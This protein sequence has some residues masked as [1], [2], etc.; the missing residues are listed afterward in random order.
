[1]TN[2]AAAGERADYANRQAVRENGQ[3]SK[4]VLLPS[5]NTAASFWITNPDNAHRDNVA[6]G[7]DSNGFWMSLPGHP[8]DKLAGTEL[9]A[10]TSPRPTPFREFNGHVA[11][12]NYDSF[13][14]DRNIAGNNPFS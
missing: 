9:S 10:N 8:N 11:H 6:A 4:D 3:A 12:S 13:M 2:L 14:F 1:P 5:D 7:S